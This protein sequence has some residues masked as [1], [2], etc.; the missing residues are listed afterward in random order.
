[1]LIKSGEKCKFWFKLKKNKKNLCTVYEVICKFK[2][3][4][5]W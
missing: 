4:N 1:M 3:K 5:K 2:C